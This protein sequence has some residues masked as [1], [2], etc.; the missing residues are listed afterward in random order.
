MRRRDSNVLRLIALFRLSKA[1]ILI[2]GGIALL[3]RLPIPEWVTRFPHALTFVA[4]LQDPHRAHFVAA[5]AFAYAALFI[6]EGTGL[7]LQKKWAEYLTLVATASFLPFEIYETV[8]KVTVLRV[9]ILC[10]NALIVVYLLWR[11]RHRDR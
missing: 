2:A 8:Q 6:V 7:W 3:H 11:V 1:A 10:V 4:K 9:A 5:A